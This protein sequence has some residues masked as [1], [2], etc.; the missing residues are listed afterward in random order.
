MYFGGGPVLG[1]VLGVCFGKVGGVVG[2]VVK[3][4]HSKLGAFVPGGMVLGM[5]HEEP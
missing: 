2:V 5:D 4:Q 3:R 1:Y